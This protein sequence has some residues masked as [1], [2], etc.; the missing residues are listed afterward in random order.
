[1]SK[2][3]KNMSKQKN[4]KYIL[5]FALIVFAFVNVAL[6]C[7][8]RNAPIAVEKTWVPAK[9]LGYEDAPDIMNGRIP[10]DAN[11]H[12]QTTKVPLEDSSI[13]VILLAIDIALIV[14]GVFIYQSRASSERGDSE[15]TRKLYYMLAAFVLL[16]A[17]AIFGIFYYFLNKS[18]IV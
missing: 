17:V 1:M 13:L 5:V 7:T 6:W 2:S 15:K 9:A 12:Y 18:R 16:S 8:L 11:E 14:I 3:T 4:S 10:A